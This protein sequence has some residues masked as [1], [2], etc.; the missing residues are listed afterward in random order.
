[1]CADQCPRLL[2]APPP[3]N[4]HSQALRNIAEFDLTFACRMVVEW[5]TVAFCLH[6]ATR[7]NTFDVRTHSK[8]ITNSRRAELLALKRMLP[9]FEER[10]RKRTA[11]IK[12]VRVVAL[13]RLLDWGFVRAFVGKCYSCVKVMAP[14]LRLLLLRR[15]SQK[16]ARDKWVGVEQNARTRVRD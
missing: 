13:R 10:A 1:M 9:A 7:M 4:P 11:C 16:R 15:T 12:R 5:S 2:T 14:L 8:A 6:T 3:A